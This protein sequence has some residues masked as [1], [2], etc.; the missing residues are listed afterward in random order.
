LGTSIIGGV[1]LEDG[2]LLLLGCHI[3][4]Q[5]QQKADNPKLEKQTHTE[6]NNPENHGSYLL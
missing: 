6:K 2:T 4:N 5:A 3:D 1:P